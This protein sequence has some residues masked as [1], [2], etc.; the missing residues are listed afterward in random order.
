MEP[1]YFEHKEINYHLCEGL[2]PS[3]LILIK[4]KEEKQRHGSIQLHVMKHMAFLYSNKGTDI[5][6]IQY[7]CNKPLFV[8]FVKVLKGFGN[9]SHSRSHALLAN[10]K[11]T[12]ELP[13]MDFVESGSKGESPHITPSNCTFRL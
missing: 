5:L 8:F 12:S 7:K 6:N 4:I 2:V 9:S 11:V 1:T 3:V 10:V 13:L